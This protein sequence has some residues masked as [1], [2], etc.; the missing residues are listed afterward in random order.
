MQRILTLL[1]EFK[2][3]FI[4][5][6][7]VLLSII[8]LTLNDNPQLK[9]IRSYTVATIGIIQNTLAMV[10]N[11]FELQRENEVLRKLNVTL[12]DETSRLRESKLENVSL[13]E[14]LGFKEKIKYKFVA[15]DVIGKTLHLQRNTI[16][17]N[18]GKNNNVNIDMPVVCEQG[19]VGRVV[20]VSTN[21]SIVQLLLNK[22]F[23]TSVKIQRSRVDGILAW[24]GSDRL[25]MKNVS[26]KQ[27]VKIG[28]GAI[29]SEYSKIFPPD[30]KVGVVASVIENPITLFK[31]ILLE[32]SVDF[33]RLEQVFVI[34]SIVDTERVNLE[35]KFLERKK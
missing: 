10:P 35:N 6:L 32:P 31:D 4:L 7:L 26:K 5:T 30:I 9:A 22:D 12:L 17:L 28:D 19:I 20:A 15:A 23:R 13:R 11:I 1:I 3:Y 2:E 8:L 21:Y 33:T 24:D 34:T 14:L 16:T 25:M 29:T 27:D 18:V